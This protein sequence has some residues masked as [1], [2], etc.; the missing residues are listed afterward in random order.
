MLG[1]ITLRSRS[2]HTQI[3]LDSAKTGEPAGKSKAL[4][5]GP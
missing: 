3:T 1:Q 4:S 5:S 2:D